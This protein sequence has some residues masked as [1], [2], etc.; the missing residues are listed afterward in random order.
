MDH[1]LPEPDAG[2]V[3]D[4]SRRKV[5]RRPGDDVV[6]GEDLARVRE[7]PARAAC[8]TTLTFG[9]RSLEPLRGRFQLRPAEVL[10]P[11]ED[12]PLEVRLLHDV[13]VDEAERP[14]PR[15]REIEGE[16]RAEASG[17]DAE[18]AR[19]L[20]P[21]LPRLSDLGEDEVAR[22]PP[23]LAVRESRHARDYRRA[24]RRAPAAPGDVDP[25]LDLEPLRRPRARGSGARRGNREEDLSLRHPG[26]HLDGELVGR[27][28]NVPRL[29]RQ[30]PLAK[31]R[32]SRLPP[33]LAARR[34]RDE[35]LP[36]RVDPLPS[37]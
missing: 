3:E 21:L 27:E 36:S 4:V 11:V 23:P 24:R 9:F 26:L 32:E 20:E 25:P 37:L 30:L 16:R 1:R 17:A 18:D 10:R 28:K 2:V 14:D 35:E 6:G 22:V 7:A 15:R 5:V 34:G 19:P 33:L 13:E 29:V 12:L 8:V 31:P